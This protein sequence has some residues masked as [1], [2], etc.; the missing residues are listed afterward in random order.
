MPT[1]TRPPRHFT[2]HKLDKHRR[3]AELPSRVEERQQSTHGRNQILAAAQAYNHSLEKRR[4]KA[5]ISE[6]PGTMQRQ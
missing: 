5:R 3:L 4:V 6:M 2:A 1:K